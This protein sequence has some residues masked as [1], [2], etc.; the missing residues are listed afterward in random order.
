MPLD[1]GNIKL[2]TASKRPIDPIELF[3]SR[4]RTEI[5]DLWLA[6]GEALQA[7]HEHRSMADVAIML[8]TGAGKTLVG[9]LAAQSLVNETNGPIVYA[10]SSIQLVEQTA[11]MA[12]SYGLNVSTY[13]R[14]DFSNNLYHQRLAPCVTTYH[15]LFNGKSRFFH[16][17]VVG[18]VFDDAHTAEHLL[19]DQFTLQIK[20][21]AL[22]GLFNALVNLFQPY[23][24]H[25]GKGVAYQETFNLDNPQ[26]MWFVPPFA[27][28]E[29][30]GEVNR[31]LV[32]AEL[33]E[34]RDTT[35]AWEY[36][37][38]RIDTCALFISGQE[39]VFTPLIIPTGTLPYFGS[40]V[41]R[42]YL[43][44]TLAADD[45][46]L[47]TFGRNLD[48]RI[49]PLTTAGECER[50]IL[51][52]RLNLASGGNE[53]QVDTTEIAVAKSILAHS[54]G[55]VLVP[56]YYRA[57]LW[58]DATTLQGD[59]DVTELIEGFKRSQSKGAMT[60]VRRYD[61]LDLPGD[62]CRV[63][64]IDDLPT[65]VSYLE[66]FQWETIGLVK[67]LRSTIASRIVQ[68]FGRISRG[69]ND[70]GVVVLTG[71]RLIRWLL[72]P[73]NRS[74]L[75]DF[76][77]KQLE[78]GIELSKQ[79]ATISEFVDAAVMCLKRNP[80]W[81]QFY[82]QRENLELASAPD[83]GTHTRL[84]ETLAIAEVEVEFG[85]AFWERD[86][87]E[88]ARVLDTAINATFD[89]S[90]NIGAWHRLWLG[91]CYQRMGNIEAAMAQYRQARSALKAL[92]P[93]IRQSQQGHDVA[94]PQQVHEVAA[95]LHGGLQ[96]RRDVL[97]EYDRA[98]AALR[99]TSSVPSTEEAMRALGQWLGLDSSR[100]DK[101]FGTGPDVL[102]SIP[103][104]PALS[105]ELKTNKKE[106]GERFY[107]KRDVGKV[108]D[109]VQW[110][111]DSTDSRPIFSAFV[112]PLLPA[113]V[114]A[115]PSEEFMVIELAQFRVL[116]EH[117]RAALQDVCAQATV[118]NLSQVV[119]DVLRR[120]NLL[121]PDLYNGLDK[122]RLRDL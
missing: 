121:W 24:D 93:Y 109:H 29:Q 30:L 108:Y 82:E 15:A 91:Y 62:T 19:R 71:K 14:G 119:F 61:G 40:G 6:Q 54:K 72:E 101:E 94:F 2:H 115:N 85:T 88:A 97:D 76:L 63:L 114:D 25:I 90:T 33:G 70:Y 64:V 84:D 35:F 65:G 106:H 75:P 44:A 8:N 18:V 22:T 20:R 74:V 50:Q 66:R 81:L 16:D 11:S 43:S 77:R 78:L 45:A 17:T 55:I 53:E 69:M 111:K 87:A 36:L 122:S 38:D 112:G 83:N 80:D 42:L 59:R 116:A 105:M 56:S 46:F 110:V 113:A 68:S 28:F 41:R 89:V 79:T 26:V 1:F 23:Y 52:P 3:R 118:A 92:P 98:V 9:L 4:K 27:L 49:A 67:T 73:R 96:V 104:G 5:N 102:W 100:P 99:G 39:M 34:T 103:D 51:I 95:S 37:R 58:Q 32:E 120:R 21:E 60:L 48:L 10:C 57:Q 117:L 31:L 86:F 47:R 12:E 13:F 107:W 7:W